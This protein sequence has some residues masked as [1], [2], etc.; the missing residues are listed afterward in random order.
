MRKEDIIT[1]VSQ[2][3]GVEQ[4]ATRVVFDEAINVIKEELCNGT[5]IYIRGLFTL[6][7]KKRAAKLGRDMSRGTSV[8]I[9]AHYVPH[10][11]FAK[12]MRDA[13]QKLPVE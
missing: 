2:R 9:P 11:K 10:A 4:R 5:P 7:L 12:E 3:T 8:E 6:A 13:I 1:K